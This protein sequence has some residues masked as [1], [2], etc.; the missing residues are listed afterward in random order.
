M[1]ARLFIP[2]Y[3]NDLQTILNHILKLIWITRIWGNVF[4]N[5]HFFQIKEI[6]FLNKKTANPF[7]IKG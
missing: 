6:S 7:Y 5:A 4:G 2:E 1:I 3:L